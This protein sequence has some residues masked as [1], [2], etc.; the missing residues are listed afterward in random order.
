MY[1][2]DYPFA[3]STKMNQAK[4]TIA[5]VQRVFPDGIMGIVV[6]RQHIRYPQTLPSTVGEG[7]IVIFKEKDDWRTNLVPILQRKPLQ[8]PTLPPTIPWQGIPAISQEIP[9]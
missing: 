5:S 6:G 4:D 1:T 2:L 9:G 8:I 7:N 3:N